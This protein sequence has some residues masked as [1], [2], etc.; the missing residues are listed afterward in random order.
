MNKHH[1]IAYGLKLQEEGLEFYTCYTLFDI[2]NT[3]VIMPYNRDL[4]AFIDSAGQPVYNEK[5]WDRSRNQQRNWDTIVQIISMRAQPLVLQSSKIIEEDLSA[6]SFGNNYTGIEKIWS[7]RFGIEAK[8]AFRKATDPVAA[9]HEDSNLV[10]MSIE[11]V[12]TA[13]LAPACILSNGTT[14][15]TY[16][17]YGYK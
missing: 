9:L 11:L 8:D 16:F 12:E 5:T 10:P 15:N 14:I 2:T 13:L 4:P 6:Y 1:G 3:G 17:E 7:F